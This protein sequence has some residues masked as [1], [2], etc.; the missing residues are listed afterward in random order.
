MPEFQLPPPA[1]AKDFEDLICDLFNEYFHTSSFK[2][3]G[4]NGHKQK[5]IDIISSEKR[6]IIQ[7]KAKDLSR[8]A[9]V[10]KK[11][12]LDDIEETIN[13]LLEKK[14]KIKFDTLYIVTTFSEHPDFDEYCETVKEEKKADFN[15][16][17]WGWETVRN[18]LL[19]LPKT[20]GHHFGNFKAPKTADTAIRERLE[21]K[22]RLEEDFA[23]W[24]DYFPE[25]R[26]RN[27]TMIMHSI[28]DTIPRARKK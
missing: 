18:R 4:K 5:G 14:P 27:S 8:K 15:V 7:C 16:I 25:N 12:L 1:G 28:D 17:C 6:M 26:K 19:Q 21:M 11:E 10:I 20:L 2:H 22:K 3:F 9:V 13:L 23:E 24:L